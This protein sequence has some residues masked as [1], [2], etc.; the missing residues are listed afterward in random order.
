MKS[1]IL[2]NI[3]LVL[4]LISLFVFLNSQS[5]FKQTKE[6]I[7]VQDF[8]KLLAD[9]HT[10]KLSSKDHETV[11]QKDGVSWILISHDNFPANAE[12]LRKFFYNLREAKIIGLKTSK[13]ELLYKLGLSEDSKIASI[14]GTNPYPAATK[15]D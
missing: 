13:E 12:T 6:E 2:V 4:L 15:K 7:L 14:L 5:G 1:E 8:D 10:I 11:I 9:L 3:A